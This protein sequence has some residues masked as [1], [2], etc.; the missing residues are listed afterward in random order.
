MGCA[1]VCFIEVATWHM[2]LWILGILKKI[3]IILSKKSTAI[4]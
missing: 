3:T 2:E 1:L 4:I